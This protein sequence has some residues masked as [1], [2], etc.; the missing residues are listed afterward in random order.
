[1]FARIAA[2]IAV[3]PRRPR[4]RIV[5]DCGRLP[6]LCCGLF[7]HAILALAI[8]TTTSCQR[9]DS[10]PF[11]ASSAS[12]DPIDEY[13]KAF[14]TDIVHTRDEKGNEVAEVRI[15]GHIMRRTMVGGR[16]VVTDQIELDFDWL[17]KQPGAKIVRYRDQNGVVITEFTRGGVVLRQ[18]ERKDADVSVETVK[19]DG[20]AALC[21]R[22]FLVANLVALNKCY[23]DSH[24]DIRTELRR[25]I[26][27]ITGFIAENSLT[28]LTIG[29]S[30]HL[31]SYLVWLYS[32]NLGQD[33]QAGELG[34]MATSDIPHWTADEFRNW[35]AE[36]TRVPQP[37]LLC[38]GT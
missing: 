29:Q 2:D 15:P 19:A 20:A 36:A 34:R 7:L 12:D 13:A 32:R 38:T 28:P 11:D 16:A 8:L 1:M 31:T 33:C 5:T 37:P 25:D 23:P 10:P 18:S 17:A 6:R 24:D 3:R 14:E 22:L 21:T 35:T 9:P 26:D 27:T 30:Q 4:C